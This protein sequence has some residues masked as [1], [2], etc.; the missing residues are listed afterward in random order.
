MTKRESLA[1]AT[2]ML[3]VAALW[4]VGAIWASATPDPEP[5]VAATTPTS[6]EP[7]T[8][9]DE[10]DLIEDDGDFEATL[11]I[12]PTFYAVSCI[13]PDHYPSFLV[14]ITEAVDN[15]THQQARIAVFVDQNGNGPDGA[16]IWTSNPFT[17][18][19]FAWFSW[20]LTDEAAFE[21][22]ITSGAWCIGFR[23]ISF[24]VDAII[25]TSAP[26]RGHT[27]VGQPGVGWLNLDDIAPG[28]GAFRGV[29]EYCPDQC[30]CFI[31]GECRV[32]DEVDPN[33]PCQLC[34]PQQ[35]VGE[36]SDNDGV[37]CDDGQ[38]CNGSDSCD[39]GECTDHDGNPCP[40]DGAFCNG[41]ES[42]DES[43]DQCVTSGNPCP[44]DG[45]FCN[46]AE[47]CD[48]SSDQCTH[49]GNPCPADDG[50]FC[51][52]AETA[53]CLEASDEC[54][55][56]GNP[57]PADDGL[58]CNGDE[59]TECLE[60]SDECGHTGDPCLE[61][62][63]CLEESDECSDADDDADDDLDD[64]DDDWHDDDGDD[65]A[66]DDDALNDDAGDDD[67]DSA[68]DD[69]ESDEETD[70]GFGGR[71]CCGC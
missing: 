36:W 33:N 55:H 69:A 60:T 41:A 32:E 48:E 7:C 46:G 13:E 43:A 12:L 58:F 18:F 28:D 35:S 29:A 2:A 27:W 66:Q 31:D 37:S 42:C 11:P 39:G 47:A 54:G 65:D 22:P 34:N 62:Q 16:P 71:G 44:D 61:T 63:Q 17:P 6:I 38:F 26:R 45:A 20:D 52:G 30:A 3:V 5:D 67:A 70:F 64:D 4:T 23:E 49:G 68:L 57:C 19:D 15:D 50:Q 25:D 56:A 21:T 9:G 51:N 53:E 24:G 10:E 14:E 40:D 1:A 8:G 59:T